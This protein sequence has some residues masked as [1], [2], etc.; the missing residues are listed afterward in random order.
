MK[1]AALPRRGESMSDS[2]LPP[3]GA[4]EDAR[5]AITTRAAEL[6]TALFTALLGLIV[7]VGSREQGT[8]WNEAGPEAGYFPFYIGVILV[9]ASLGNIILTLRRWKPL[10]IG[11]V[12]KGP[13]RHVVAVFVPMCVY[14]VG[15]YLLGTYIASTLFIAWFMWRER[16]ERRY[17]LIRIAAI[18]IGVS[19][20]SYLIFE[21][22]F[23]VPLHAGLLAGAVGLIH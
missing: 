22:W 16:G 8:G 21:L 5:P 3:A 10:A 2:N 7:I 6:A 15:I 19:V 18:S 11:F 4:G 14:G 23:S 20:A 13:F 1:G 17:S 12:E 9:A